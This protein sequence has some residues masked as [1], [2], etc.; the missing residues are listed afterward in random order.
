LLEIKPAPCA[1]KDP[2]APARPRTRMA[3]QPDAMVAAYNAVF[4]VHGA[5]P[6]ARA[7]PHTAYVEDRLRILLGTRHDAPL[8]ASSVCALAPDA[9]LRLLFHAV[10]GTYISG[11]SALRKDV[12]R[13]EADPV[14][15]TLEV[16]RD[17]GENEEVLTV[18]SLVLLCVLAVLLYRQ[19]PPR[20]Q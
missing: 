2:A 8:N 10:A 17:G 5:A 7:G 12:C 15:G 1:Y 9:L 19:A 11:P 13:L 16:T 18:V 3:A 6:L 14:T 20:R 4:S